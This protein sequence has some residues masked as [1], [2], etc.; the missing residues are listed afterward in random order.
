MADKY[1]TKELIGVVLE[2]TNSGNYLPK[3]ATLTAADF[4]SWRIGK[5]TKGKLGA[6]GQIFLTE[7]NQLIA[8][9]ATKDLAF[10]N[11]HTITP[12][13]RFLKESVDDDL[14]ARLAQQWSQFN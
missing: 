10:K 9:V 14:L 13:G 7:N 5:H 4:H 11:R 1:P 12:M 2:Q 3:N 6:A 8:L